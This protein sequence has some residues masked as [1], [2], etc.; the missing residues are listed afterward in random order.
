M[1]PAATSVSQEAIDRILTS[2]GN[3][4]NSVLRI[5]ANLQKDLTG[6]AHTSFL[7]NEYGTGG[8][9]F[10]IDGKEYAVWFDAEGLRVAPGRTTNIPGCTLVPWVQVMIRIRHL[11]Q[12]G[13]YLTPEKLGAV[14]SNECHELSEKL[15]YLYQDFSEE[16]HE[17]GFMPHLSK[18]YGGFPDSTKQIAE[19]LESE[20]GREPFLN[21]LAEFVV[22][23]QKDR[24]LLRFRGLH[25]PK[26]LWARL[27][28]LGQEPEVFPTDP[29]FK[30]ERPTFITN[31]ELDHMLTRGSS[32]SEGKMR[33]YSYFVQG[34]DLKERVKFLRNEY[35]TGGS[36]RTGYNQNHDS[37]GLSLTRDDEISGYAGYD[38]VLL[39]WNRVDKRIGELIQ[40][41]RYM[42]QKEMDD[43]P[44]YEKELLARNIYHFYSGLPLDVERPFPPTKDFYDIENTVLPLLDDRAVMESIHTHMVNTMAGIEPD[45]RHYSYNRRALD[46]VTAFMNGTYSLFTPLPDE[47]LQAER[48]E[49]EAAKQ[50]SE[51]KPKQKPK[52]ASAKAPA[53]ELAAA[54]RSLARK[55]PTSTRETDNGQLSFDFTTISHS[56]EPI[57][58]SVPEEVDEDAAILAA[59]ADVL[60]EAGTL[61]EER[62]IMTD[63]EGLFLDALEQLGDEPTAEEIADMVESIMLDDEQEIALSQ[64]DLGYGHMGNGLTV[65]NALETEGGDYK[66]IAHIAPDR[67]VTFYDAELPSARI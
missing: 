3:E 11:L 10:K 23:Y 54:A 50:Q 55:K 46:N 2:G 49:K 21:E 25:N 30:P 52:Q 37:K 34:H 18:L 5:T 56:P 13:Q 28:D 44:A 41:G 64:Y 66:T 53:D 45:N 12:D 15:W 65:W 4:R 17:Q 39:N 67:T 1:F 57:E 19:L 33:I 29:D 6:S 16:A 58:N 24:E 47:V 35:G 43:I 22:A 51:Q 59:H 7:R 26:E 61:L 48:K 38:T 20:K 42:N 40:S 9:G 36:G 60:K 62:G 27:A 63:A 8:K 14:R 31:D 32:F